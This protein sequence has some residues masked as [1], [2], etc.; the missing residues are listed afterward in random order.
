MRQVLNGWERK[1][2]D[3]YPWISGRLSPP[4]TEHIILLESRVPTCHPLNLSEVQG[5]SNR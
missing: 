1:D 3:G 4:S 2:L 5:L